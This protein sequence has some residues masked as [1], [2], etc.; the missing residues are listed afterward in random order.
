[1]VAQQRLG[2]SADGRLGAC[3]HHSCHSCASRPHIDFA[4][5]VKLWLDV[6]GKQWMDPGG[7]QSRFS[8]KK[9]RPIWRSHYSFQ[10]AGS[11][12]TC[13]SGKK[14]SSSVPP[15]IKRE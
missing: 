10:S 1:M 2:L 4:G 15:S 12:R 14:R 7:T 11:K 8:K 3:S 5:P 6:G 13:C 9:L